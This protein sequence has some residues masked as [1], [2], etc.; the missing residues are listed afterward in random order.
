MLYGLRIEA[1][2]VPYAICDQDIPIAGIIQNH[3]GSF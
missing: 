2:I 1:I 3:G